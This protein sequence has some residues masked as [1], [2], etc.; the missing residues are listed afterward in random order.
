MIKNLRPFIASSTLSVL[1]ASSTFGTAEESSQQLLTA[2]QSTA[3]SGFVDTS[4]TWNTP[5][6][7]AVPEPSSIAL[8]LTGAAAVALVRFKRKA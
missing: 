4:A 3:I 7:P 6:P 8:L 5:M 1:L 2:L